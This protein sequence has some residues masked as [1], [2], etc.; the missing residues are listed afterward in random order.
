LEGSREERRPWKRKP[1]PAL[2]PW[3]TRLTELLEALQSADV[4]PTPQLAQAA[5][6]TIRDLAELASRWA[7]LKRDAA[8]LLR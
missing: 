2:L 5:E 3:N 4:A 7:A 6:T 1:T 8:A